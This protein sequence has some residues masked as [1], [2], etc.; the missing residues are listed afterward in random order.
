[1][2]SYAPSTEWLAQPAPYKR[3]RDEPK[4]SAPPW[5]R[6]LAS[7][8]AH[9]MAVQ[10]VAERL[11][12]ALEASPTPWRSVTSLA[13]ELGVEVDA[14]RDSLDALG[15]S[16]RTPVGA[17]G[18]ELAWYRLASDGMTWQ[19]HWRMLKAVLSRTPLSR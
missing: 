15:T 7:N 2:T 3:L 1:M 4:P 9:S 17:R 6:A 16:V 5:E 11:T 18:E 12:R 8:A 14:V 13:S 19:E 10:V